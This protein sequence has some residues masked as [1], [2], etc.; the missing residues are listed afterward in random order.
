MAESVRMTEGLASLPDTGPA[1]RPA[2]ARRVLV[3]G[4]AR[5]WGA[6][7]T[8]ALE[9]SPQIEAVIAV[10]S[11]DPVDE[12][13]RAEFVRVG[14]Q[15]SLIRRIVA[16][17]E[18]DA[19]VDTRLIVDSLTAPRAVAH[20]VNVIGTMNIVAACSGADSPVRRLVLKSSAHFY[21]CAQ[22]DPAFFREEHS[23]RRPPETAIERDVVEAEAS[24]AEFAEARPDVT[25]TV[26]RCAN[27]L[28]PEL[29]TS[30][31]RLLGLPVVP[32]IAGFDPRYQFVHEEDVVRA[33]EHVTHNTL[34]G[35]FN[36]AA[37]GVLALSEV[38]DL[39][40]KR[41]APLLPPW[42]TRLAA[43]GLRATGLPLSD[44]MLNQLRFGRG[45]DN[46]KLKA[47]GFEYRY[48]T[49]EAVL[50]LAE[51]LRVGPRVNRDGSP[52][53]YEREVEEFLRHSP[54]ARRSSGPDRPG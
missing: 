39:L 50:K 2:P 46:R 28:G 7:L 49:R 44:E 16:A 36:V 10:D 32:I 3:T 13:E 42:G 51:R 24:V 25:V 30:H 20:E 37:D 43:V 27:V 8:Q 31:V 6:R 21:G 48:T 18:I 53:Q 5:Q 47:T 14:T 11:D 34:P 12:F 29:V 54:H 40:G 17:A 35:R 1:G 41:P 26:L 23:R 4:V 33:L 52:Y 22:D 15:Y 9:A 38:I 19:V 45:L